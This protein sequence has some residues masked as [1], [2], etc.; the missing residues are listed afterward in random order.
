MDLIK[1]QLSDGVMNEISKKIGADRQQTEV[2]TDNILATLI[3]GLA[4]NTSKSNGADM[5]SNVLEKDHDG[6][7]LNNLHDLIDGKAEEKNPRAANGTGILKHLLGGNIFDVTEIVSKLS[8][9]TN[10]KTMNLMMMLAPIVMQMLGK[11][12]RQQNMGSGTLASILANTVSK[13]KT[14]KSGP[15]GGILSM[16]LDKDQ[17]GSIVDDL[18]GMVLGR[19]FRR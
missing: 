18:A 5:L 17:D 4:K 16:L 15:N 19:L 6:S 2:A 12:K 8:G 10:G 3:E 13:V 9:L 14:K 11:Q 1:S 7:L